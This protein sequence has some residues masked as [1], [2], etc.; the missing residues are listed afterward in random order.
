MK[1]IIWGIA[2]MGLFGAQPALAQ[3]SIIGTI[4]PHA[5]ND[6]DGPA[7]AYV[8][9]LS[10]NSGSPYGLS[11]IDLLLDY[12]GRTCVCQDFEDA[13]IWSDPV[14]SSTGTFGCT[15]DYRA[16][17]ECKGDPSIPGTDNYLLKFEPMESAMCEPGNT[18][19]ARFVFY[20]NL[21]P[22]PIDEDV[23]SIVDKAGRTFCYG[24]LSGF[25]P[26]MACDP[27]GVEGSTWGTIKSQYR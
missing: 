16:Y 9:D 4:T 25:F 24:N 7:W 13:L 23:L 5:T 8:V 27:V 1:K 11:H 22:A 18:G 19:T 20:S 15:V 2:L 21:P 10:W 14:G 12:R 26:S 17:L 3:C 6:P